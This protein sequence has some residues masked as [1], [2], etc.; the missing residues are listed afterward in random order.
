MMQD[1]RI[2]DLK[3]TDELIQVYIEHTLQSIDC[4]GRIT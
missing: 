4:T 2:L 3:I 1:T